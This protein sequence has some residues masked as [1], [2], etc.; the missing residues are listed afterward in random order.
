MLNNS[1]II[2]VGV[3]MVA[4]K[5]AWYQFSSQQCNE[6]IAV[7]FVLFIYLRSSSSVCVLWVA[8]AFIIFIRIS[9]AI[10][11]WNP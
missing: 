1:I 2:L 10:V 4:E 5:S 6:N 7:V 3:E 9:C 8:N 11:I